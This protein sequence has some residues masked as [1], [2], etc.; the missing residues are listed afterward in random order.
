MWL[1]PRDQGLMDRPVFA[2][3]R[4]RTRVA[5]TRACVHAS[6]L[7]RGAATCVHAKL[8]RSRRAARVR[9]V[10]RPSETGTAAVAAGTAAGGRVRGRTAP[11]MPVTVFL[12]RVASPRCA[13]TRPRQ[14]ESQ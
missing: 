7:P 11:A 10:P 3:D 12:R 2:C 8:S 9:D 4:A 13:E 6:A 14:S 5:V 1:P